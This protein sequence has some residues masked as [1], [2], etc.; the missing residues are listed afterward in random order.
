MIQRA[1]N[2]RTTAF[3]N[4]EFTRDEYERMVE[5]RILGPDERV[6]LLEGEIVPMSPQGMRH[7]AVLELVAE[8]LRR[9][10][11]AGYWVR[12]Q[13]SFPVSET[14]MPEPDVIVVPGTPRDY[15]QKHPDT[16]LLVVE[17]AESSLSQDRGRKV[18]IYATA[19][20]AEYWVVNLVEGVLE[21]HR[22]PT[23]TA[24]G[25]TYASVQRLDRNARIAPLGSPAAAIDVAAILP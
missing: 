13:S 1:T 12:V 17:V 5:A 19:R 24:G 25:A 6:E 10:F 21:V 8:S 15:L 22:E 7:I 9:A 18:R 11:G 4:R 23:L 14:S 2:P 20:I 3:G 16:A